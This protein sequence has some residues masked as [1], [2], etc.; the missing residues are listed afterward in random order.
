MKN[1]TLIDQYFKKLLAQ[2]Q[3]VNNPEFIF[4]HL[5]A[6]GISLSLE[7]KVEA[8][9]IEE[10]LNDLPSNVIAAMD[11][12]QVSRE[13]QKVLRILE[14]IFFPENFSEDTLDNHRHAPGYSERVLGDLE[15]SLIECL[16]LQ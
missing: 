7:E 11:L 9:K 13:K 14:P 5:Y 3:R 16:A 6:L 15:A 8:K 1:L 4:C 10:F 12:D 2:A